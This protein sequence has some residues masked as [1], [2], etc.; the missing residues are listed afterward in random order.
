MGGS[1]HPFQGPPLGAQT[2]GQPPPQGQGHTAQAGTVSCQCLVWPVPPTSHPQPC[3]L[4]SGL[5][6]LSCALKLQAS[7]RRRRL[8]V[9]VC[10]SS[11][12]AAP[13]GGR[14]RVVP[15]GCS[16]CS[17]GQGPSLEAKKGCGQQS[18]EHGPCPLRP[19]SQATTGTR[20]WPG[21]LPCFQVRASFPRA[22]APRALPGLT[23]TLLEIP[24]LR[25]S[26]AQGSAGPHTGWS[27]WDWLQ[28]AQWTAG[29]GQWPQVTLLWGKQDVQEDPNGQRT[30]ISR[31]R[32]V[33]GAPG[34]GV[35][36]KGTCYVCKEW[37]GS[38]HGLEGPRGS[39]EPGLESGED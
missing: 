17:S 1:G 9:N 3:V 16:G 4:S 19:T 29:K 14:P 35:S 6:G 39:C 23:M 7:P 37:V 2:P 24:A 28:A 8:G 21:T 30:T 13:P 32:G 38:V 27:G 5:D 31:S 36:R 25:P 10:K 11:G 34:S 22:R 26:P 12:L 20:P 15:W 18:L 33:V